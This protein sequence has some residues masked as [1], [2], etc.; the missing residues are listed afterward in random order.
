[1]LLCSLTAAYGLDINRIKPV[2]WVNDYAGVIDSGTKERLTGLI[3]E[4]EQ[5]TGAEIAVVTVPSLE[6]ENLED[7]SNRLFNKLGV[8]KK[9]KDNGMM[10]FAAMAEHK[11]RIEAGYGIEGIIPDAAAGRIIRDI[12]APYFRQGDPSKGILAGVYAAAAAIAKENNVK[13]TGNYGSFRQAGPRRAGIGDV[14]WFLIFIFIILPVI[15]RNPWLLLLFLFGGRG[16]G[17]F[18]GG[19]FGGGGGFGGGLSG[20]GG[21]SGGW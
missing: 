17:G 16:R 12:M 10:F 14:I 8:G 9:G 3:S 4:L 20:G 15:I 2:G 7:F 13:L 11:L 19:S 6:G 18:G 5:K 1:M 21:A